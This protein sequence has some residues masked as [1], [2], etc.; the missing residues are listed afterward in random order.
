MNSG[1]FWPAPAAPDVYRFVHEIGRQTPAEINLIC[2]RDPMTNGEPLL[3]LNATVF[4]DT[5]EEAREQLSVFESA[6][7]GDQLLTTRLHEVTDTSA[8]S[9]AGT[10]PHYDLNWLT[11]LDLGADARL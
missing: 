5:A 4:A 1:Y 3:S 10:D 9:R 2:A 8:L 6:P 7:A 11:I